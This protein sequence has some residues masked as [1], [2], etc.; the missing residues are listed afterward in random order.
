MIFD[1]AIFCLTQIK[2]QNIFCLTFDLRNFLHCNGQLSWQF[3]VFERDK[4]FSYT[5][6]GNFP[7]D[8]MIL[9]E[10]GHFFHWGR[11]VSRWFLYLEQ[12]TQFLLGGHFA[13]SCTLKRTNQKMDGKSE[14]PQNWPTQKTLRQWWAPSMEI[15]LAPAE[16]KLITVWG[17]WILSM[18]VEEIWPSLRWLLTASGF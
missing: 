11:Q 9:N 12:D 2:M 15:C 6:I 7:D 18:A 1:Y 16:F 4:Q 3:Y 8:F 13:F 10:W 17:T 14:D 5:K